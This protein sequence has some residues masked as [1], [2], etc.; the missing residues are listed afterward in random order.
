VEL[1][2]H[3]FFFGQG[4]RS[5]LNGQ[6]SSLS[7]WLGPSL[8]PLPVTRL[9]R[10]ADCAFLG[11]SSIVLRATRDEG[12][13]DALGVRERGILIHAAVAE[14]L[15]A[16]A[17][18]NRPDDELLGLALEAAD[19]ALARHAGSA[20]RGAALRTTRA[21][22]RSLVRWSLDNR[23]YAFREA[24]KGFGE[25]EEWPPLELG[26]YRLSGRIDRIDVSSD[27][28]RAR[29]IDYKS[30]QP[31][32]RSEQ[33]AL[34]GWLYARKVASE[35]RAAAVQSLYLGLKRRV[36]IPKQIFDGTPD[37]PDLAEREQFALRLLSRLES[38]QVAAEPTRPGKCDRC[39]A[40]DICRRP[41]SAPVNE[42][43]GD[44]P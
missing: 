42:D 13:S 10:Y 26:P 16:I 22:V 6:V 8:P 25:G 7:A 20:L 32:S 44:D 9:E 31:P 21:D 4:E 5:E 35:L 12:V 41:L 17:G 3:A 1:S 30:G 34:Q 19:G 18:L 14:A 15:S 28:T 23:E 29:V 33:H 37:A 39:D 38:G 11:F 40:R 36:P 24:E 43:N 27:G 2:R